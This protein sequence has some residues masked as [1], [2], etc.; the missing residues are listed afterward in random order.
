MFIETNG[1][2]RASEVSL[3]C[4]PMPT[5]FTKQSLPTVTLQNTQNIYTGRNDYLP[6]ITTLL[7]LGRTRNG[8][9]YTKAGLYFFTPGS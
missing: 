7:P 8:Y 6:L 1:Q 3:G 9:F 4:G 2:A 5:T